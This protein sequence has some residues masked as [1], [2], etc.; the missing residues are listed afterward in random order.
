KDYED[1]EKYAGLIRSSSARAMDLLKNL[2]DWALSQTGR[3]EFNPDFFDITILVL[4]VEETLENASMQKKISLIN[5]LPELK[6]VYADR[7]MI[8]TVLRNLI[9]N[10]IKF[11]HLGGEIRIEVT[12]SQNELLISVADS[13]VG[14][15]SERLSNLFRVGESESTLGTN[16]EKGTGL[17]L[18][19]C[20]EFIEKHEGKIWVESEEGKGSAFY[21][22]LP[23]AKWN[24]L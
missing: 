11:T 18:I 20:K 21:I 14:I 2:M 15:S 23:C 10:A 7:N 4:E 12:E 3:M 19:L 24:K 16:K 8:A 17:G 5:K 22:A 6:Q 13:G 9:S 1:I